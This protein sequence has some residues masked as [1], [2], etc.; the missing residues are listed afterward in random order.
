MKFLP[1]GVDNHHR[2][3]QPGESREIPISMREIRSALRQASEETLPSVAH[4]LAVEME[5]AKP[6]EKVARWRKL[7]GAVFRGI[8]PLDVELQTGASTFKLAQILRAT[9]PA[10]SEAADVIIP[11]IRPEGPNRHTSV[12]SI[13]E[14]DEFLFTSFPSKVLDLLSATV[15]EALPASVHALRKALIRIRTADPKLADTREF[16]KL[17]GYAA[18]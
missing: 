16:Q 13:A 17:S 18:P 15:G 11:F 4:R 3:R 8:W 6:G 9:G 5:K 7:V 14:A 10:F 12:Y 1:D 2:N